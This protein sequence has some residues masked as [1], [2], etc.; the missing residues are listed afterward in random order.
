MLKGLNQPIPRQRRAPP[1]Q[2]PGG[3]LPA[4]HRHHTG[5][6]LESFVEQYFAA[7]GVTNRIKQEFGES[8]MV[9]LLIKNHDGSHGEHVQNVERIDTHIAEGYA[10][11]PLL[12]KLAEK[13]R[14]PI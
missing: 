4:S 3:G 6:E 9:D 13:T 1:G 11:Q 2:T 5:L 14:K 8:V 10:R 12:Q 7:R